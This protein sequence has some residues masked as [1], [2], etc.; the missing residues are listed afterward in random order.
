MERPPAGL[1]GAMTLCVCGHEEAAHLQADDVVDARDFGAVGDQ[2]HDDA[3][4][5]QAA[6]D[7]A[8]QRGAHAVYIPTPARL[9]RSLDLSVATDV[10]FVLTGT[11]C[12]R[13]PCT[14]F[15]E[16]R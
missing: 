13:C 2:I 9:G 7:E 15:E 1:C 4:A 5:I 12:A 10:E 11:R 14:D 3:P 6:I 8:H 16:A